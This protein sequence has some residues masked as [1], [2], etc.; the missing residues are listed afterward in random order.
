LPCRNLSRPGGNLTGISTLNIELHPERLEVVAELVPHARVIALLVNPTG[1]QTERMIRQAQETARAMRL[2]LHMLEASTET[3][4]D[5]AFASLAQ[6][7]AGALVSSSDP[8]F[9]S[10]REQLVALAARHAVPAIYQWRE[11]TEAGGLISYGPCGF[12]PFTDHAASADSAEGRSSSA[13]SIRP[14]RVA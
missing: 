6:L 2:Q 11:F 4:I 10:R 3:A 9:T 13:G 1:P 5:A 14:T 7:H 12:A 8:F